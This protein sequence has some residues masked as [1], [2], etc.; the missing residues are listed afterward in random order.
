VT[1]VSSDSL[2]R[3]DTDLMVRGDRARAYG[4]AADVGTDGGTVSVTVDGVI[5]C[6]ARVQRREARGARRLVTTTSLVVDGFVARDPR[7]LRDEGAGGLPIVRELLRRAMGERAWR[8]HLVTVVARCS[9]AV[10]TGAAWRL[11]AEIE[12]GCDVG[13][14][15]DSLIAVSIYGR[16]MR[17]RLARSMSHLPGREPIGEAVARLAATVRRRPRDRGA[18]GLYVRSI[19]GSDGALARRAGLVFREVSLSDVASRPLSYADSIQ[20]AEEPLARGERCIVGEVDGQNAFRMWVGR[21]EARWLDSVPG[22]TVGTAWYVHDCRTA[23]EFRRRG[24]YVAALRWLAASA[25]ESGVD[26]I[27]LHVEGTNLAAIGAAER[28]GFR[29]VGAQR[30]AANGV[31]LSLSRPAVL[32]LVR[33]LVGNGGGIRVRAAGRSMWP[34]IPDGAFVE[35]APLPARLRRGSIVLLDWNGTAVLHRVRRVR[36]GIVETQGDGCVERDPPTPRDRV[37]AIAVSI[38]HDG[39][40][41]SAS[42]SWRWGPAAWL[43][44]VRARARLSAARFWR[45]VS[46]RRA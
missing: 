43:R 12:A 22:V 21:P 33:E 38:E 9:D 23:P 27:C 10:V 32:E 20:A 7:L 31:G 6:S 37:V 1:V 24:I 30:A 3:E 25:R 35:L 17:S 13:W 42:A 2:P 36:D 11:A 29:L 4:V 39:R 34:T 15:D 5:A 44:F 19:D 45:S 18:G 40:L 14:S 41:S 16:G 28:A 46:G 26:A 8:S